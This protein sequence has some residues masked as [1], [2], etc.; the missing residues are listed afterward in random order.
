MRKKRVFLVLLL[1]VTA[2]LLFSCSGKNPIGPTIRQT[3]GT[4]DYFGYGKYQNWK[5]IERYPHEKDSFEVWYYIFGTEYIKPYEGWQIWLLIDGVN[6]WLYHLD[7]KT[8]NAVYNYNPYTSDWVLFYEIPFVIGN[9]WYSSTTFEDELF[10]QWKEERRVEVV[11]RENVSVIAGDYEDCYKI[12]NKKNYSMFGGDS[13]YYYNMEMW[14]APHIGLVK[15]IITET[16]IIEWKDASRV[17]KKKYYERFSGSANG[18]QEQQSE[19]SSWI[20]GS[21]EFIVRSK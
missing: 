1:I 13:T 18:F 21:W 3:W 19:N 2:I 14:Y 8:D 11:G 9:R 20:L 16:D 15:W 10:V 4:Y 5:Y 6:T 12:L 17:L 7:A